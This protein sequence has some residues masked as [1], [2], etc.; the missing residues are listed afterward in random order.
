[1]NLEIHNFTNKTNNKIKKKYICTPQNGY[2]YSPKI[3][4]NSV[5]SAVSYALVLE[6]PDAPNGPFIHWYIPIIDKSVFEISE[7]KKSNISTN[8]KIIYGKN[9]LGEFGYY[10]PCA[11]D[12]NKHNYVFIIYSLDKKLTLNNSN[13]SINNHTHFEKILKNNKIGILHKE[14]KGFQ[15]SY[16]NFNE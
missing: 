10:G 5:K 12:N 6:D 13:I 9:R 8:D 14:M 11:P 7:T 16:M 2:S 15:Y 3:T 1:M 4:W